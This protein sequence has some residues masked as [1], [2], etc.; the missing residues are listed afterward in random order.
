MGE[1]ADKQQKRK[2]KLDKVRSF[3]FFST[4]F[5]T[6]KA[7]SLPEALGRKKEKTFPS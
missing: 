6:S 2:E 3:S 4:D 1:E 5:M 7:P